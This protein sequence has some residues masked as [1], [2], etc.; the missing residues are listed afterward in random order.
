MYLG[1][2]V[3]LNVIYLGL[4]FIALI[5]A[6]PLHARRVSAAERV[7]STCRCRCRMIVPAFNE[8]RDDRRLR[9]R[10]LL[11]LRYQHFEVIVVNDGSKDDTLATYCSASSALTAV[12]GGVPRADQDASP[13]A[14]STGR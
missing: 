7:Y 2:F 14:A 1:Y 12:S 8:A 9:S 5:W 10:A 6:A 4:A 11:Q 3:L 13:C